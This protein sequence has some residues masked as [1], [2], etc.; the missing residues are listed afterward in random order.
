MTD[1]NDLIEKILKGEEH[2]ETVQI[3]YNGDFFDFT[4]RP[5]T[6]KELSQVQKLERKGL[7][8]DSITKNS[9][10]LSVDFGDMAESQMK[11]MQKAISLSL[12]APL[13]KVE[14]LPVS[15]V[16]GLFNEVIRVSNLSE[17]ELIVVRN[18][19]TE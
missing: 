11:A 13:S 18:F 14:Q 3:E 1:N 8:L 9:E 19:R 4:L 16:D 5:L 15:V 6:S 10:S 7:K 17:K 2:T 12:D